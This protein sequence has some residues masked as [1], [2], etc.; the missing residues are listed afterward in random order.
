MPT[1]HNADALAE[2]ASTVLGNGEAVRLK[3][4]LSGFGQWGTRTL[5]CSSGAGSNSSTR[6]QRAPQEQGVVID[7]DSLA[8]KLAKGRLVVVVADSGPASRRWCRPD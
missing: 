6:R 7:A 1:M 3:S 4:R 5:R 8:G 2:L